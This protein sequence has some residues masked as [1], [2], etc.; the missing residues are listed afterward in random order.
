MPMPMKEDDTA[1]SSS[2]GPAWSKLDRADENIRLFFVDDDDLY[3][4]TVEAE[5]VEEG[6]SVEAFPDGDALFSA[7]EKGASADVVVLD[8]G[9]AKTSGIDLLPQLRSRGI[10]LPVVFLT[11][12]NSPTHERLAFG[13]GAVDFIDKARG[14]IILATRLRLV[15]NNAALHAVPNAEQTRRQKDSENNL[16][17]VRLTLKLGISRAFWDGV[18][19]GLTLTEYKIVH[20]LA[21]SAGTCVTYREI[22]DTMHYVGF[23]A[24][25]GDDGYRTNVRSAIKRI[26]G[27]F[28]DCDADFGEITNYDALGYCWGIRQA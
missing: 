16:N 13:R 23:V 22:Y 25:S 1:P 27:K 15:V 4:D 14:T 2:A 20:R 19:V 28:R 3:R 8:W 21:L 26:R 12:R 5:L 7:L 6:F 18:D 11:G 10:G 9:L 17:H 24:G